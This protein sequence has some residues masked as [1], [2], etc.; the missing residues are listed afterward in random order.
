MFFKKP[1]CPICNA[2]N[3]GKPNETSK[4]SV[5]QRTAKGIN[6]FSKI[7][8]ILEFYNTKGYEILNYKFED[9]FLKV[10]L[11]KKDK[12]YL[13]TIN[14]ETNKVEYKSIGI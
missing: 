8:K 9:P 6:K 10:T 11:S 5:S 3:W 2:R 13:A 7:T 4:T 12:T 14:I 1:V